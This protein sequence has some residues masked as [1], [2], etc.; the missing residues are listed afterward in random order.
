MKSEKISKV[1]RVIAGLVTGTV[2]LLMFSGTASVFAGFAKTQAVPALLAAAGVFAAGGIAALAVILISAAVAGRFYCA[3]FCPLGLLQDA[4]AFLIRR[5]SA[6]V[7]DFYILRYFCTAFAAGMFIAGSNLGFRLLDPYSNAGRILFPFTAGGVTALVVILV[8]A[9]W[10]KRIFCTAVCPAGTLLGVI[11]KFSLFR[12]GITDK[13]IFCG[14]C[15]RSCPA[16]CIDLESRTIDNERCI[17]CMDCIAGC[18]AGSI[19]WER[20]GMPDIPRRRFLI[21]GTVLIA[22][23]AAGA[24]LAGSGL[25]KTARK[26][27]ILPPGAGD[28]ERFA[29]KCTSCM[30]CAANCPQKIIVPSSGGLGAV[31]LDLSRGACSYNCARC[32][33]ICPAGALKKLTLAEKRRRKIAEAKFDPRNCIAFQDGEKCGKCAAACPTGAVTL[34]KNGTPRPVKT[35]LCI[36]CGACQKVCPAEKKAM[37][38]YPVEKQSK[39]QEMV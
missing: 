24:A 12:L 25:L 9:V 28:P 1:L 2:F 36:G 3:A 7:K 39:L 35:A 21:S 27:R 8:L 19:K 13:C 15:L 29:A 5:K 20:P 31:E 10:K 23:I 11:A 30:L 34:R 38:V 22:G 18:P 14:K 26:L 32:S 6:K 4:A 33:N 37:R 16:G 17:R